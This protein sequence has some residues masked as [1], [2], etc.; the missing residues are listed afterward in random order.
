MLFRT[1]MIC[2]AIAAG[3]LFAPAF[4]ASQKDHEDCSKA[5]GDIAIP[6]CTRIINDHNESV[7]NR[8]IAYYNRGIARSDKRDNDRAIAD[9]SETI[10]LDPN[11]APPSNN[12]GKAG[13]DKGD[14]P[15]GIAAYHNATRLAPKC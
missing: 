11:Y 10:R 3:M 9:Y 13:S 1:M 7:R 2:A 4:A 5:G 6:S 8:A 15:R 14:P 12:R